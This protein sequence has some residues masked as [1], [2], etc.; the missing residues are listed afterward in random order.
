MKKLFVSVPMK[1]RTEAN[2]KASIQKMKRIAEAIEGE[3]LE[4][5][6]S[7]IEEQPPEGVHTPVW[8]LAKSIE[9]LAQAD[10]FIGCEDVW[11]FHGCEIE[12]RVASCYGIKSFTIHT[13]DIMDDLDEV[14][15]KMDS[16]YQKT[17]N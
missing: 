16:E 2:I 7:Y 14:Q 8:Y 1:H 10:V 15:K 6:D 3:E 5:I 9:L 13:H 11:L 17:C 12:N 4:L